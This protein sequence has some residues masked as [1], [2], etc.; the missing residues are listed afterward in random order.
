M[1]SILTPMASASPQI[2]PLHSIALET[3]VHPGFMT[4][5]QQPLVVAL[6]SRGVCPS[7]TRTVYENAS[8]LPW[9]CARWARTFQVYRSAGRHAL[10]STSILGGYLGS[11]PCVT[12]HVNGPGRLRGGFTRT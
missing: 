9:R 10:S 1:P 3:A 11:D 12:A 8:A 6:T 5:W 4:D 2:E 7:F